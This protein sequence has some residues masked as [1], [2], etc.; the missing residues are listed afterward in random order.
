MQINDKQAKNIS[1]A[2]LGHTTVESALTALEECGVIGTVVGDLNAKSILNL[3]CAYYGSGA[4]NA[5]NTG[6]GIIINTGYLRSN[7]CRMAQIA[8]NG[9]NFI[10][11]R[12]VWDFDY[13]AWVTL[14]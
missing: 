6:Y 11:M 8:T 3:R 5:P 4:L 10:C 2:I 9:Q 14:H 7:E 12:F 1:R 13:T